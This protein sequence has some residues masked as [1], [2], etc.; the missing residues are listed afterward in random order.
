MSVRLEGSVGVNTSDEDVRSKSLWCEDGGK[1]VVVKR[2]SARARCRYL[3]SRGWTGVVV[4]RSV[5]SGGPVEGRGEMI[6]GQ[7]RCLRKVLL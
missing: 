2:G 1:G 3:Y 7:R 5:R 6:C 4:E